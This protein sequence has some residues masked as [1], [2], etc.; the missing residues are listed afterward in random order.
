MAKTA[1]FSTVF[2]PASDQSLLVYL[3]NRITP[4][5]HTLVRKL[6]NLLECEPIAG[7]R[8][9]HPAYCSLLVTFGAGV[10]TSLLA[11]AML[12]V[13]TF[14]GFVA[15]LLLTIA[16][17]FDSFFDFRHFMKRK[18]DSDESHSD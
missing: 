9:L 12:V 6:L 11:Y 15:P 7:V 8:N 18:D 2:Q 3:G 13:L 1:S 10:G 4:K 17:L 16:G 5:T 14:A